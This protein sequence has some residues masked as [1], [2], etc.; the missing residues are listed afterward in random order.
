[1]IGMLFFVIKDFKY[2]VYLPKPVLYIVGFHVAY[3]LLLDDK[4][5]ISVKY[6]FAKLSFILF[7]SLLLHK[8]NYQYIINLYSKI[9]LLCIF[10][11]TLGIFFGT[12]QLGRF[13]GI[14]QNANNLSSIS[15]FVLSFYKTDIFKKNVKIYMILLSLTMITMS[16]SRTG[17]ISVFVLFLLNS[18]NLKSLGKNILPIAFV[19]L[20]FTPYVLN[21]FQR[22][23]ITSIFDTRIVHWTVSF[24][25]IMEKYLVG[26]GLKA[27]SGILDTDIYK[28]MEEYFHSSGSHSAILTYFLMFGIPLG[29]IILLIKI[30][31]VY[32]SFFK[33]KQI[34][35]D[36]YYMAFQFI[37]LIYILNG[38][39]ESVF[40]GVN[41]FSGILYL[42]S[43][44][45]LVH[46]CDNRF[47]N[48]I[49]NYN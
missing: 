15:V 14:M 25:S 35:N 38:I 43:W 16:A 29:I 8:N 6:L 40:T 21:V 28:Q 1:M 39:T 9:L 12:Y 19:L 17:I 31:P 42:S 26:H 2:I 47:I 46:F 33:N 5:F 36:N 24:E 7:F 44:I 13:E 18:K 4:S 10:I 23:S 30:Y 37:S 34:I 48:K 41:D 3:F 32:H 22:F 11:L 27:Y 49:K 45:T 20:F